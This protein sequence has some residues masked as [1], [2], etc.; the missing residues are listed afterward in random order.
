MQK[1]T[2]SRLAGL[3]MA[4][5]LT[6][7][8]AFSTTATFESPAPGLGLEPVGGAESLISLIQG[9]EH[10][11]WSAL[12]GTVTSYQIVGWPSQSGDVELGGALMI[13][14]PENGS[15]GIIDIGEKP[16]TLDFELNG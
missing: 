13:E 4:A 11:F 15:T 16:M 7:A 14:R 2:T 10:I 6:I 12:T 3:G 5:I 1:V 9:R 8:A